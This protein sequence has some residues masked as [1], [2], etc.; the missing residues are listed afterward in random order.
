MTYPYTS[1]QVVTAADMNSGG[2]HLITPSSVT[3]G[4]LDGATVNFTNTN[5]ISIDGVFS[6]DFDNYRIMFNSTG[7][8]ASSGFKDIF[9]RWRTGAGDRTVNDYWWAF[10]GLNYLSASNNSSSANATIG[11][12]GGFTNSTSAYT[13]MAM[14]VFSPNISTEASIMQTH[15]HGNDT[16]SIDFRIGGSGYRVLEAHTGITF[17]ATTGQTMS[18]FIRVYGY[19][20][21]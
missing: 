5:A 3:G 15:F 8:S 21:G 9:Y 12:T 14:D 10:L 4:T 2:L 6:S 7:T 18:G 20:N 1:G 17:S 13:K 11:Y 16:N 19:S